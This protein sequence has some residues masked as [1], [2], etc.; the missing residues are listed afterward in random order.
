MR[1]LLSAFACQ[2]GLGSEAKVGW[3]AASAIARRHECHVMTHVMAK[4]AIEDFAASHGD[5]GLKFHYFGRP[6]SWHPS[7]MIARLQSWL[8][9][10]R[11]QQALL[12]FATGLHGAHRFD[13]S[14][15][16]TYVTWRVPSPLWRMPVPFVWGPI[17]GTAS[18]PPSF[19]PILS[20]KACGFE[21]LRLASGAL[22]VASSGF[23]RCMLGTS[24][25]VA[26]NGEAE[27][28]LSR[29]RNGRPMARLWPVFFTDTELGRLRDAA[30]GR[31]V[32]QGPLRLFAGG[33]L[34]GRKG[35]SLALRAIADLARMGT[36]VRFVFA[37][38]GPEL[39][40]L[41]ALAARLGIS[42]LVEFHQGYRGN[43]YLSRLR[44]SDVYFLPSFRE[45]CPITLLEA[46]LAG[47]YPI[48]ADTSG[49]GEIV[50]TV[51]GTAVRTEDPSATVRELVAA[52]QWADA[53]RRE[54]RDRAG[55]ASSTVAG[56]FCEDRYLDGVDRIYEHA[57]AR[58]S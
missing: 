22:A 7:R 35:V 5:R 50:R 39:G 54:I 45:T 14:H 29:Y 9:Y 26:A 6:F 52:V 42:R 38:G 25:V 44:D 1:V 34:E 11:W 47:C 56:M 4:P 31:S 19:L 43:E 58:Q 46:V 2:P 53:H 36:E 23:R 21:A 10:R 24:V 27:G 51:G 20:A 33:N 30:A 49:A 55:T 16:V 37:G 8:V 12:P 13:L 17:G 41:G 32:H 48:V 15:H 3:D 18:M 28:F 40:P 57:T